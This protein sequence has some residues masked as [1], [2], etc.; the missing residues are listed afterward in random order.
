MDSSERQYVAGAACEVGQR[1]TLTVE[2]FFDFICPWCLIGKRNLEAA[3]T[4]FTGLRPDV[5]LRVLWRSH[6]LLPF[7]PS[8]GEPYQAFYLDR[9][10]S[11][12]AVAARRSQVRRAGS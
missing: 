7:T 6:R 10:G 11:L 9:L 8:E 2:V 4:R 3:I 1:R 5:Q 12:E